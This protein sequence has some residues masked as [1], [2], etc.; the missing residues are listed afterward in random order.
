MPCGRLS[1]GVGY[2]GGGD[3]SEET[4]DGGKAVAV[5]DGILSGVGRE[6]ALAGEGITV[7]GDGEGLIYG[8][9]GLGVETVGI[10]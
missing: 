4:G 10:H 2:L 3:I 9:P 5:V 1:V 7:G 6:A 8:E